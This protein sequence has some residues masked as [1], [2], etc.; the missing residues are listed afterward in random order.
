MVIEQG[1]GFITSSYTTLIEKVY[2]YELHHM[3]FQG[4][5]SLD[6]KSFS[7][8][9]DN[10]ISRDIGYFDNIQTVTLVFSPI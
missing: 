3:V 4:V 8:I 7:A 5:G 2:M 6:G 9:L 10:L 1:K